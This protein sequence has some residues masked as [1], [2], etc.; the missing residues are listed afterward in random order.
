MTNT[1]KNSLF[2][3]ATLITMHSCTKVKTASTVVNTPVTFESLQAS[4]QM[5]QPFSQYAKSKIT[6]RFGTVEAFANYVTARQ[7]QLGTG[8]KIR[9]AY[10]NMIE[11][12]SG[13]D[14]TTNSISISSEEYILDAAEA[15]SIDVPTCER[16]GVSSACLGRLTAGQVNQFEQSFLDDDQIDLGYTLLCVAKPLTDATIVTFVEQELN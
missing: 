10:P 3:A 9:T 7:E 6:A 2:A 5:K 15:N 4:Y 13:L 12:V 14:G 8:K 16:A 1:L 11:F